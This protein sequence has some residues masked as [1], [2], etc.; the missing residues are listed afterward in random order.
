M[1]QKR[2]RFLSLSKS[3][4]Y[5]SWRTWQMLG[6]CLIMLC[7]TAAALWLTATLSAAYR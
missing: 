1:Y 7:S 6:V 4:V 5:L 3:G 2:N